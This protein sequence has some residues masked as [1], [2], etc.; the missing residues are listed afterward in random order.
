MSKRNALAIGALLVLAASQAAVAQTER[1]MNVPSGK[2]TSVATVPSLRKDCS[3]GDVGGIKVVTPPKN[4]TFLVR[5]GKAKTPA[6][7][8]CP[9][10]ETPIQALMYQP[11]T[12]FTGSDE[13]QYETRTVDGT[14]ETRTVKINVGKKA[15][16]VKGL[17]DL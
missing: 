1:S 13:L 10:V 3:V 9:N 16:D 15:P 2:A 17:Q 6:T 4:G 8:R 5:S 14:I 12:G 11:K 7:F